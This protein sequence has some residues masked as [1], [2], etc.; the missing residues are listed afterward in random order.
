MA[1]R[2]NKD[3]VETTHIHFLRSLHPVGQGAF[4]TEV[5][6]KDDGTLFT[7]VYDCGSETDSSILDAQ[8]DEFK[9]GITQIDILFI[10]HF[11]RDHI[12]GL[13]KLLAGITVVKTVIPMLSEQMVTLARVQNLLWYKIDALVTDEIIRELYLSDETPDRFGEVLVVETLDYTVLSEGEKK[14]AFG[15]RKRVREG[16]TIDG[17]ESLWEYMPFNSISIPDQ[18]AI[19]FLNGLK[20][21]VGALDNDGQLNVSRI[22]RGCRT[23]VKAL[24]KDVMK[25]ANENMYTMAVES[26][27]STSLAKGSDADVVRESRCLYTG[28]FDSAGN[29]SLW[30]RFTKAY[31]YLGIGTVQIPHHG[32]KLNWRQEFLNGDP[33]CFFI[34]VGTTNTYHHPDFWVVKDVCDAKSRIT[35]ITEKNE[36]RREMKYWIKCNRLIREL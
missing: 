21:I 22:I 35:F 10:S 14:S 13:D 17:F 34:S 27:P 28:D 2:M 5:F 24:Y 19:D 25:G 4:Y 31:D 3:V 15:Q 9:N 23:K 29:D 1:L 33:R 30:N 26:R 36:T 11:H 6:K 18:R 8:I 12:S 7:V 16:S 32:S 20:G